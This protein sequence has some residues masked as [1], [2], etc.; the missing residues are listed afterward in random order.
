MRKSYVF[1]LLG[2]IF[3]LSGC[4]HYFD[5]GN[6]QRVGMLVETSIH[7]QGWGQKGYKGLLAIRDKYDVDVYYQEDITTEEDVKRAVEELVNKGVN[8][9]FGHSSTYGKVF[10]DISSE[11]PEVQFVYFNGG[12]YAENVAS[13]NFSAQA[14]GYFGGMIASKMTATNQVGIVAAYEWQPEVEGF[15]EG[16]KYQNP[17]A[18]VHVDF[19]NDWNDDKSA[20]MSYKEMRQNDVDV[21]YPAGDS[22]SEDMIE[23]ASQDGIYAFGYVS[24]RSDIDERTVLTSTVQ[25]ADRLY[26]RIAEKFNKGKLTGQILTFD[27]QDDAISLGKFSPDV[28]QAF[29]QKMKKAISNY[30]ESGLLPNEQ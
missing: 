10:V 30:K 22:F 26:E 23:L 27:F 21:V 17:D 3:L 19:V 12:Y 2:F 18:E 16:A 7:D 11:Y 1:I 13:L 20:L 25:H 14:M 24:D 28:P 9:I 29:Q 5:H 4:G 8:L 6:I 15:Y